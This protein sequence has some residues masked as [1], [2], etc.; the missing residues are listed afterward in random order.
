MA[1]GCPVVSTNISGV[2][3]IVTSDVDG[4]LV[5]AGD[6]SAIADAVAQIITTPETAANFSYRGRQKAEEK[7][8]LTKNVAVL[9]EH[10]RRATLGSVQP[11]DLIP[12]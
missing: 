2:P 12:V 3:E 5:D 6:A 4:F 7:F 9:E 11:S 1:S 10:F 8:D